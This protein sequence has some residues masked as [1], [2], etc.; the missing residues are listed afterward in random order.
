MARARTGTGK[1]GL[2]SQIF[3]SSRDGA[4]NGSAELVKGIML[5]PGESG[6]R[7]MCSMKTVY[8]I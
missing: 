6:V 2:I 4:L 3:C 5:R 8:M 7:C 1:E